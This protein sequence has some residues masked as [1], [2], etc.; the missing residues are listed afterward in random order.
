M[1]ISAERTLA[2]LFTAAYNK[3]NT[4]VQKIRSGNRKGNRMEQLHTG[5]RARLRERFR[6]GGAEVLTDHEM[7][8]MLLTYAIPRRDTNE[9]A[10]RLIARFGTLGGVLNASAEDLGQVEGIGPAAAEFLAFCGALTGRVRRRALAAETG[11]IVLDSPT[12][13]A[14]Y[15]SSLL[16]GDTN[17]RLMV[18]CLDVKRT[19]LSSETV[20]LGTLAEVA[21]YPR[22]VAEAA[23]KRHA[24]SVILVHN[25]P[26]GDAA[27]SAA[28][29]SAT[30]AV[31]EALR[32]LDIEL[33]DHIVL[34][35]DNAYSFTAGRYVAILEE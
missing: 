34:G 6:F 8:E 10:H 30:D 16:A 25:H 14:R 29:H 20:G 33:A 2:R 31:R 7:L 13:A 28:D 26:S 22:R 12:R 24:H 21:V 32:C 18:L 4:G 23:L 35:A 19:F 9:T 3:N 1:L 27:P 17:E 5:H 11:R 15:A